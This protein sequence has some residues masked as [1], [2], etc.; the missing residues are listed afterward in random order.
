MY[1]LSHGSPN[2]LGMIFAIMAKSLV[3]APE[4]FGARL[5]RFRA[6]SGFTLEQVGRKVGLSKRMVAYYEI[7]GGTP[8][9]EQLAAFAKALGI[10]ADQLVG[11]SGAQAA[12]APRGGG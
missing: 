8:S 3:K 6:A 2:P 5:R 11:T 9:P 4:T 7:Q 10:S 1:P 12:D